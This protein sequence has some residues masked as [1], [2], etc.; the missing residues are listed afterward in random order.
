MEVAGVVIGGIGLVALFDSCMS[1]FE[2]VDTGREYGSDFQKSHLRIRALENR[3][4]RWA[5]RVEFSETPIAGLALATPDESLR[6][7]DLLGS[8]Q[9]E[10]DRA[11]KVSKSYALPEQADSRAA[12]SATLQVLADR[13]R[14]MSLK[15]RKRTS[16]AKTALWVLKDKKRLD[17]LISSI[18]SGLDDLEDVFPALVSPSQQH[19]KAVID[20]VEQLVQ[21][22]E[23][24]EPSESSEP[25]IEVLKEITAGVDDQLRSAIEA[26]AKLASG[27]SISIKNVLTSDTARVQIGKYIA[28]D[29]KGPMST[30]IVTLSINDMRTDGSARVQVGDIYG[31]KN[32][33][34]D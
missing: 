9:A 6:V 7:E 2:L 23:V 27:N 31:G 30:D 24:E 25:I 26:A 32:L 10:L 8:I 5:G 20:D 14:D 3:L 13:F 33:M 12:G 1:A 29:Y 15:R 11:R 4:S 22:A 21:P 19:N 16:V 17:R 18:T 28:S 34:D